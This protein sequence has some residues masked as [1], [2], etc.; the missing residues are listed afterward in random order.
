MIE[1]RWGLEPMTKR[2]AAA[3]NLADALDFSTTRPAFALPTYA[4]DPATVCV[5]PK[6]LP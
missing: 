4:V 5:N 1:W 6:H 3:K 2:D